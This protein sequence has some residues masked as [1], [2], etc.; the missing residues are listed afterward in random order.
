[1]HT[2]HEGLVNPVIVTRDINEFQYLFHSDLNGSMV[3]EDVDGYSRS[4]LKHS[5]SIF[6]LVLANPRNPSL[7]IRVLELKGELLETQTIEW[8]TERS[9]FNYSSKDSRLEPLISSKIWNLDT[10]SST[11]EVLP[12]LSKLLRCCQ[13]FIAGGFEGVISFHLTL[14]SA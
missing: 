9:L 10:I 12:P 2:L 8:S 13:E 1:V 7:V 14:S 5:G 6:Q 11:N 4:L 3:E